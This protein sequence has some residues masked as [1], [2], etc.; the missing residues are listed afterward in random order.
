MTLSSEF[1]RSKTVSSPI[2]P[3]KAGRPTGSSR[4]GNGLLV[5]AFISALEMLRSEAQHPRNDLD[6]NR[7]RRLELAYLLVHDA[8]DEASRSLIRAA[9]ARLGARR[10][11]RSGIAHQAVEIAFGDGEISASLR[12]LYAE[13]ILAAHAQ[14]LQPRHY[15]SY[16]RSGPNGRGGLR[17]LVQLFRASRKGSQQKPAMSRPTSEASDYACIRV[18]DV[19][20]SEIMAHS[21][22]APGKEVAILVGF[23]EGGFVQVTKVLGAYASPTDGNAVQPVGGT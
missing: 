4:S 6:E 10:N 13:S 11:K 18:S 16:V 22:N 17:D 7:R 9:A 1:E 2:D 15:I 5:P 14:G 12:T 20:L 8:R 3:A 23:A 19:L 21:D